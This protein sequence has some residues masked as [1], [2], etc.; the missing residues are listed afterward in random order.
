MLSSITTKYLNTLN[1]TDI[2]LKR[3]SDLVIGANY[4][5]C[6]FSLRTNSFGERVTVICRELGEEDGDDDDDDGKFL[7][8][9]SPKF[10]QPEK[11]EAFTQLM[12]M[13]SHRIYL[14]LEKVKK[15][16]EKVIPCYK[17]EFEAR[18]KQDV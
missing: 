7:Y 5:I 2:P 4:R 8:Y 18:E 14:Q 12:K 1:S 15:D 17:F 10:A 3:Y 6:S 9:L 16:G 13:K 11:V